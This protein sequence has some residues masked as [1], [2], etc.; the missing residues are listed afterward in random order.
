MSLFWGILISLVLAFWIRRKT[1]SSWSLAIL[2]TVGV[3]TVA[4]GGE[5]ATLAFWFAIFFLLAL[6]FVGFLRFF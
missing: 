6:P 2:T 3:I 1:F 4:F 5:T